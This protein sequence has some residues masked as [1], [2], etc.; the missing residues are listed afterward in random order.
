M[1]HEA[2]PPAQLALVERPGHQAIAQVD[3]ISGMAMDLQG[4]IR[5]L[6]AEKIRLEA[7]IASLEALERVKVVSEK[8][9]AI[10]KRRGRRGMS[11]EE[12]HKVSERMRNYWENRRQVGEVEHQPSP[13]PSGPPARASGS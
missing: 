2:V 13:S 1:V 6:L 10:P 7:A 11:T 8:G 5:G 9:V 4:I 12:R 3:R